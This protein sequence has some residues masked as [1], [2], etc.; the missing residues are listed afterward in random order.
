LCKTRKIELTC[1]KIRRDGL[2]I[3]PCNEECEEKRCLIEE[4]NR[5]KIQR[6]LEIEAEK[7]RKE[8]EEYEKKFGPKKF[9]ERKKR[10]VEDEQN[11]FGSK[12]AI[13]AFIILSLGVILYLLIY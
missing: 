8:L 4:E 12:A 6:E 2:K 1:D 9:K 11:N 5:K 13:L 3:A 10:F 7:N